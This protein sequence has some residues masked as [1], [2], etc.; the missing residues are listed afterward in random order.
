M[1]HH[2]HLYS[3]MLFSNVYQ[4]KQPIV[5]TAINSAARQSEYT[6]LVHHR[7]SIDGTKR[8]LPEKPSPDDAVLTDNPLITKVMKHLQQHQ[9]TVNSTT[10]GAFYINNQTL[11]ARWCNG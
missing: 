10:I 2:H 7:T 9:H 11:V 8:S 6:D 5:I 1:R 4:G 3:H